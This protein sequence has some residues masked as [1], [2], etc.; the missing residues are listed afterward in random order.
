MIDHPVNAKRNGGIL[1]LINKFLTLEDEKRER[2]INAAIK[3]FA[4]KGYKNASTNEIVKDAGISKGLLFHYFSNKKTLYLFLYDYCMDILLDVIYTRLN[5]CQEDIFDRLQRTSMIKFDIY[6]R[7]PQIYRF[8][9]TAT[10]EED[11]NVHEE[12]VKRSSKIKSDGFVKLFEDIDT[13]PFR[14]DIDIPKAI[15]LIIWAME[16]FANNILATWDILHLDDNGI[17]KMMAEWETYNSILKKCF[18]Q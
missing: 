6:K 14:K 9:L 15:N 11:P 2:I 1:Y 5:I 17:Q 13:S 10:T 3:E 7:Y 4:H 18:Y 16:G 8:T 12:I